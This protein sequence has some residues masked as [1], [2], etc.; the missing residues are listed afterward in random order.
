MFLLKVGIEKEC[1]IL[2][3]LLMLY[4]LTSLVGKDK[5]IKGTRIRKQTILSLFIYRTRLA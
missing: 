4:Q 2:E 5:E 1:L 3:L